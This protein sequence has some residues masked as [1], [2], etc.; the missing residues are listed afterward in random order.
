MANHPV[1]RYLR[2]PDCGTVYASP[3]VIPSVHRPQIE[4]SY[5]ISPGLQRLMDVRRPALSREA[6]ILK[7]YISTGRLLDVG[8][9]SGAFFELFPSP[10]WERFGVELSPSTAAY[11]SQKYEASVYPGILTEA[12]Y[13]DNYFDLLTLIDMF[14]LVANPRAEL[15]EAHRVL[16]P[17]GF[18]AIE[19]AGQAYML[20]R[21]RGP[22]CLLLDG[23]WARLNPAST[24]L[25][26]FSPVGLERLL[27]S[28]GFE[29][30]GHYP[31]NSPQRTGVTSYLSQGYGWLL[32][33][34]STRWP[35]LLTWA[36]KFLCVARSI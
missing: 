16:K 26:W 14:Y 33:K 19:I 35:A 18:I 20:T 1:A 12:G 5:Q 7:G 17:G 8:C 28:S 9:S 24:Y 27:E 10:Y 32:G 6:E 2:C 4:R 15:A 13:P 36:P 3:R 11:A 30:I 29:V 34:A 21:S 22:L 31:V 25:Y 23:R